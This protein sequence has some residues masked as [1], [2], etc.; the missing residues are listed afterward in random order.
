LG[1]A[2]KA[3]FDCDRYEKY[4]KL[5][6]DIAE[7]MIRPNRKENKKIINDVKILMEDI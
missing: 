4:L 6:L 2:E 7:K 1:P 5:L 3:T